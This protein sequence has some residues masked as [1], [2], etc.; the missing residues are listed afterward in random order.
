M[1]KRVNKDNLAGSYQN[2]V[3][4]YS[5]LA[6]SLLLCV[7]GLWKKVHASVSGHVFSP[8]HTVQHHAKGAGGGCMG[9]CPVLWGTGPWGH[10]P[11]LTPSNTWCCCRFMGSG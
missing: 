9:S 4:Q 3:G 2:P 7:A 1:L 10:V 6:R 8:C 5:S 11:F